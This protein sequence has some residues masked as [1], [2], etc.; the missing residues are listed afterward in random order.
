[1]VRAFFAIF[2]KRSWVIMEILF[3]RTGAGVYFRERFGI[4]IDAYGE[5]VRLSL[6]NLYHKGIKLNAGL[7]YKKFEQCGMP[8]R[9]CILERT[10]LMALLR[11]TV[12]EPPCLTRHGA[13]MWYIMQCRPFEEC[14]MAFLVSRFPEETARLYP[15]LFIK[16]GY[17]IP[18]KMYSRST[19]RARKA[20]AIRHSR[21]AAPQTR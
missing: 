12:A 15:H 17:L 2:V 1:M 4:D 8:L 7:L 16:Q 10:R 20:A 6:E 18:A 11:R 9:L 21:S 14:D 5:V 19:A 13:R 3:N